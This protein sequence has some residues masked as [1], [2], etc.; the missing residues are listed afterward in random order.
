MSEKVNFKCPT[1]GH[2]IRNMTI[3]SSVT[4]GSLGMTQQFGC[5]CGD[6]LRAQPPN[7]Y[8]DGF[9]GFRMSSI[10]DKINMISQ[11]LRFLLSMQC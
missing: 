11:N 10:L 5:W 2:F 1:C 6:I 9:L 3:N 8:W 4:S 7:N